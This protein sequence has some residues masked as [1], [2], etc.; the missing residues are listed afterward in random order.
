[1]D[2]REKRGL[3]LR[4]RFLRGAERWSRNT[5]DLKFKTSQDWSEGFDP[6]SA[7]GWKDCQEVGQDWAGGVDPGLQ[8]VQ[9]QS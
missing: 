3:A 8:Q 1:M 2:T 9:S 5:R 7:W 6:E 4:E